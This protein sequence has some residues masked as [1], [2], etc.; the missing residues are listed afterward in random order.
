MFVSACL[1]DDHLGRQFAGERLGNREHMMFA[2][3]RQRLLLAAGMVVLPGKDPGLV[4]VVKNFAAHR[5]VVVESEAVDV[6]VV[7]HETQSRNDV[8]RRVN[9]E[10]AGIGV[11]RG[12]A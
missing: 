10:A 6:T 8:E 2:R 11:M 12:V 1:G 7:F 4:Q 5:C 9:D 3:A